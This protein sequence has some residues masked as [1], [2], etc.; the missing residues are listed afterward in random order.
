MLPLPG[1]AMA[2]RAPTAPEVQAPE[3]ATLAPAG[4]PEAPQPGVAEEELELPKALPMEKEWWQVEAQDVLDDDRYITLEDFHIDSEKRWG[5]I[6][7]LDFKK[8]AKYVQEYRN[9][10]PAGRVTGALVVPRSASAGVPLPL[11]L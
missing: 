10:P 6:R 5:Q 7:S 3:G 4:E 9:N 2:A 8:V 11:A 1:L